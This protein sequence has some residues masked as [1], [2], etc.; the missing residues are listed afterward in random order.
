MRKPF[1]I[2]FNTNNSKCFFRNY[3]ENLPQFNI[4]IVKHIE[5]HIINYNEQKFN[6]FH[7]YNIPNNLVNY[8]DIEYTKNITNIDGVVIINNNCHTQDL[9]FELGYL[10]AYN[11]SLPI[12]YGNNFMNDTHK[13][14]NKNINI[15]KLLCHFKNLEFY[16]NNDKEFSLCNFLERLNNNNY[17]DKLINDYDYDAKLQ[18]YCED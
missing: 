5:P 9:L 17:N 6:N 3:M 10:Y 8:E 18:K 4:N 12:F 15:P 1:N 14:N 11:P 2:L 16:N 7:R 13:F